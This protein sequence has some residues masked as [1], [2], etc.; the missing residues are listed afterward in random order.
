VPFLADEED[1]VDASIDDGGGDGSVEDCSSEDAVRD[2]VHVA[3]ESPGDVVVEE[4]ASHSDDG[5]GAVMDGFVGSRV[6][7]S[8]VP[9]KPTGVVLPMQ[10]GCRDEAEQMGW[11]DAL[12]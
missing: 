9:L 2:V 6:H 12:P 10:T 5:V 7:A 8:D 4:S 11:Q 3:V 1:R